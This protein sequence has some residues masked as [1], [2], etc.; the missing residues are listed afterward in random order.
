MRVRTAAKILLYCL[1]G[2]AGIVLLLLLGVKLA[3]DRAPRYQAQIKDWVHAQT[4]YHVAFAHVSPALRWYGPEL[5][6]DRLELRS[7]DDQ[8]VL[9]RAA[10][11]RVAVDIWQLL[12]SGRLLA[13]RVELD[14]P[15]IVLARLGTGRFAI[16]S[17][18]AVA[19]SGDAQ[20]TL[21]AD[22]VPAGALAI[23]HANFT[24]LD[25]NQ[26]LPKLQLQDVSIDLRH[27]EDGIGLVFTGQ[28]PAALG[29]T[30]NVHARARG[31][32]ALPTLAWEGVVLARG[33]SFPGWRRLLPEYLSGLES[34][35]ATF[36]ISVEGLGA[37]LNRATLDF[38]ASGV[39]TRLADG[40][41]AKF[42][43]MS[44]A[45]VLVHAGDRWSLSGRR[46]RA[47]RRD[48]E[49]AFDVSWNQSSAGLLDLSAH[50]TY[51]RIDT[52]LPLA[53]FLP[54]KNLR[55]K[56]REVAP[57]GEWID[58]SLALARTSTGDPWRLK[59]QAK[60]RHAGFAPIGRAPGLRGLSGSL[61]GDE[62]GG[63]VFLDADGAIFAWPA[64]FSQPI[65][66]TTFQTKLYWKRSAGEL[67]VATPALQLKT[68]DAELHAVLSWRQPSDD[69]SPVLTLVSSVQNGNVANARNYLPRALIAPSAMAWLDRAFL[70][71][72]LSRADVV[73]QGPVRHF[74][75][76]DGSGLFLARLAIDGMTLNY[77]EGWPQAEDVSGQAEFRNEGLSVHMI[78]G[79][80]GEI[81]LDSV[82][83]RF[84]DFKTGELRVK[85]AAHGDAGAAIA[86]LQATP[87]DAQA[88]HAFSAVEARGM[89]DATVD[90]FLPFRD[91]A[92]R[93]VLV[94][95]QLDGAALNKLGDST[96]ATD[97][98]GVFDLENA[99]VVHADIRGR[100][101]GGAFQMQA[102]SPRNRPA[103][104]TQLEFRGSANADDVRGALSVPASVSIKGETDWRA[105]LKMA[106]EPVRER[107][108]R[109]SSTLEG[110]EMKLPKPLDKP[111]S[112]PLPSWLEIQ[113]PANGQPQGHFALGS[114]VAG[115]YALESDASGTHL[116]HASLNFG[117]GESAAG[118]AQIINVGGSLERV[119]LAGWLAL[120]TPDKDA[121]PLSYYLRSASMHVGELD[122]LGLAFRDVALDF[123]AGDA[124]LHIGVGGPNVTGSITI[125]GAGNAGSPWSLQFEKLRFEVA[126]RED[127]DDA[128]SD[129]LPPNAVPSDAVPSDAAP[130]AASGF[131]DPRAV[132]ALD[133][134]AAQLVW[135]ERRFGDVRATLT[136][137]NDGIRLQGL[138]VAGPS[139]AVTAE[140][141]WRG[142]H[143]GIAHIAGAVTSTDVQSTLKDLGY[144]DVIQAK[145]GKMDFDLTWTGPPTAAAL[146]QTAGH[147]QLSLDKG[148][149]TGLKPGAGRVLGLA[150]IAALPRR[151]SLDFSDLT[152]KGLAFDSVRG[153]FNLRDG[154]AYTDNVLLKGPAAEIGLI[155]RVG[156]KNKDYDQTAVVTGNYTSSL[157]V[158]ALL[159]GPVVA[160]A[161]LVFTQVFK[162]PL[163]GLARGYYRITGPWDN[164]N[165]ERIKNA[166]AGAAQAGAAQAGAAQAGATQGAAAGAAPAEVPK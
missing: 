140:G 135:G 18:I 137:L 90:L 84:E 150:S 8:R 63:H 91:F 60:F 73:L 50:A 120:S 104:R 108:L 100:L 42:D 99:Q 154:N 2:F 118:D 128:P 25:W 160:G 56:I 141:D 23:R 31:H 159:G 151:L 125:P 58:T 55:D 132:P 3:L 46:V 61:A 45:L 47:L 139:F 72:H 145:S 111:A 129:A 32:G 10:G 123:T 36:D 115:S 85:A 138:T 96:V 161:V 146:E 102:R 166:G 78:S 26:E 103:T 163:K 21:T 67:L 7:K 17:E 28:L 162:Q 124:G 81:P 131:S 93:R 79:R 30:L 143:A 16:A 29:G 75:F 1:A 51:L 74:P 34:G 5:Y 92:N 35:S 14:S 49:S 64:E 101:L 40:P 127:S 80:L 76:R 70:A 20:N 52:L 105:V 43:E 59:V 69:P 6:F 48:P 4:G 33:V 133:F 147:V 152:D 37:T 13:G 165:V 149:V 97:L 107:S 39:S 106:P 113:W 153:D 121:K 148:Q 119:D 82:E 77:G 38:A 62:T 12:R 122:Y 116:A 54:Q 9:A 144:A 15:D 19:G 126:A 83:A 86:F 87:L 24:L 95:G 134:H 41:L 57:T 53:G 117:A 98:S 66:F 158:A 22:D 44:G 142:P 88:E 155:G 94:H 27:E 114:L 89:L 71:G 130:A 112:T 11:G 136:K 68:R 65:D 156:L 109:L 110:L 157:P 164:P